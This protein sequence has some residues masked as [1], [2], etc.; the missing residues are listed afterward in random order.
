MEAAGREEVE[1]G[2]T[3]Q[4]KRAGAPSSEARLRVVGVWCGA[5]GDLEEEPCGL[6]VARGLR[7]VAGGWG[8]GR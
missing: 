1:E 2:G 7:E 4:P 6:G 8:E 3:A 5:P